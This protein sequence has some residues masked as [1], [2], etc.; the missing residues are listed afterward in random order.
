MQLILQM[1]AANDT[2]AEILEGYD[3]LSDA[4]I[5][6]A[7]EYAADRLGPMARQAAE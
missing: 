4:D 2:R 1:L 3:R 5:T 6:A 7:L